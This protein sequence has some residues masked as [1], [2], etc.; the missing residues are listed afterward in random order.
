MA[1]NTPEGAGGNLSFAHFNTRS[2]LSKFG[3]FVEFVASG[4]FDVI[5]L[6]ETWLQG[7]ILDDCLEIENYKLVRSDRDGRGGGVAFYVKSNLK[8]K[9]VT[10]QLGVS[11]LEQVWISLKISGKTFCFGSL[12]R[13]PNANLKSCL[14][15]LE[16]SIVNFL[17][18]YDYLLFG[19]DLNVDMSN[20]AR[21]GYALVNNFI[22]D[23][24]QLV[25][26]N[27]R[28]TEHTST[29][30]DILVTSCCS[31]S[32]DTGVIGMDNI[33]DHSLVYTQ[34][35]INKPSKQIVYR[36][37]RDYKNFN[38]DFFVNDLLN[39]NWS[40]ICELQNVDEMVEYF[41]RNLLSIF[42]VHA[43]LKIVAFYNTACAVVNG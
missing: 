28:I 19:G 22:K 39:V 33:S 23:L 3:D 12:Y 26:S 30:L 17:P 14:D 36:T 42:D 21:N 15:D 13:P 4:E 20:S 18:I 41:N 1:R 34:L 37:Y 24:T 8:Y 27:T 43:P 29:L 32:V 25:Q 10:V 38:F 31:L 16:N 40:F 35:K 5:G 9:I 11:A 7:G 2:L 6:S